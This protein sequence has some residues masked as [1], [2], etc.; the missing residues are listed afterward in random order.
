MYQEIKYV[1][2]GPVATIKLNRPAVF[3]ALNNRIKTELRDVFEHL[4]EDASI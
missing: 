2:D 3:N 4:Q 1:H